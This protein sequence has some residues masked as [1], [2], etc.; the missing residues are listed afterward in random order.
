MT[1]VDRYYFGSTLSSA[2]SFLFP[3][4]ILWIVPIY[5][6][7]AV[8]HPP[9]GIQTGSVAAWYNSEFAVP[10]PLPIHLSFTHTHTLHTHPLHLAPSSPHLAHS[11]LS[12]CTLTPH[13]AHTLTLHTHSSYLAHPPPHLAHSLL[14]PCRLAPHTLH[15]YPS[16]LAHSLLTP[17][18]TYIRTFPLRSS[19]DPLQ[20]P[21]F[22]TPH[23]TPHPHP[24]PPINTPHPHPSPCST[25]VHCPTH[26]N[27]CH[28][29]GH[30]ARVLRGL[31][32]LQLPPLPAKLP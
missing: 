7:D 27:C 6:V 10:S 11:P 19:H 23:F 25:T 8:S 13:L 22:P 24:H 1:T 17:H 18:P 12:P 21:L 3:C 31:R 26:P 28:L 29:C 4:R 32:H 20:P 16:H 30:P 2:A 5:S 15:T 9:T 14:T